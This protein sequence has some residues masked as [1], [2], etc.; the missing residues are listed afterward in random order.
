MDE[1]LCAECSPYRKL[2]C[3]ADIR[4]AESAEKLSIDTDSSDGDVDF[5]QRRMMLRTHPLFT[6]IE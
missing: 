2:E 4:A 6:A 5:T 3:V 1:M